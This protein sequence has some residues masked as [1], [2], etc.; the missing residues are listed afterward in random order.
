VANGGTIPLYV[1]D[2]RVKVEALMAWK[3]ATQGDMHQM[4]SK[5]DRVVSYVDKQ[6]AIAETFRQRRETAEERRQNFSEK[7]WLGLTAKQAFV[8]GLLVMAALLGQ[9][10]PTVVRALVGSMFPVGK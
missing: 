7:K 4:N 2:L 9:F 5:L 1:S 3:D 10:G 6:E 8:G